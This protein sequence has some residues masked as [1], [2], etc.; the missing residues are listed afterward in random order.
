M[1]FS[2]VTGHEGAK[3]RLRQMVEQH[4]LP[5]ALLISAPVGSGEMMLARALVQFIHCTG[6][7]PGDTDSCGVC[8]SCRQHQ[9][10]NHVDLHFAFP[11]LKKGS[12]VTLCD[13]WLAEWREFLND[14][15]WMDFRK[16][17][18]LLGKP[19]GQPVIYVDEADS[20]RRKLAMSA[21]SSDL[22]V[23]LVWLPEKMNQ[24]T[25][26]SLLKLIEEPEEGTMFILVSNSAA[27][28]LPTIYS[29]CQ[30]M[31]LRRLSDDEVGAALGDGLNPADAMAAAHSAEGNYIAARDA[32]GSAESKQNLDLFM[33]LMRLA[34]QRKVGDLK[35][36]SEEVA[37][38]G[39]DAICRFLD[40]CQRM[41]RENFI[42]NLHVADLNYLTAAEGQ[43]SS[44][45][46]PFINER[47]VEQLIA[48][49]NDAETDIRGNAGA[50][51]VLFD[52]AVKIIILIKS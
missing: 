23:A 18:V 25:A 4:R 34:Y 11:I 36:W 2:D 14:D 24:A 26:N 46:C 40:Y 3:Q 21:R 29:R 39:R 43:F 51:I 19:N 8:P 17:P 47:N 33:R 42:L 28:V 20:L 13:D 31:E 50:K 16:W 7:K 12:G 32:L 37:A 15:P 10:L 9:S 44:R 27:D 6:R 5:H 49:F 52:L 30:R 1:K 22:N 35:I 48:E 38:L 45:F 41:V